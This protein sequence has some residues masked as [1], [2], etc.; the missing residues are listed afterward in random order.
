M[1]VVEPWR[2]NWDLERPL[3]GGGQGETYLVRSKADPNQRGVMKLQV[4]KRKNDAKS[5]QRMH[6]EVS[7][8]QIASSTTSKVPKVLDSNTHLHTRGDDLYFV[9]EY[10]EGE[11]LEDL[12]KREKAISPDEA[13]DLAIDLSKTLLACHKLSIMHRDLKPGNI[14]IRGRNPMNAVI[15]DYGLSFNEKEV[16]QNDLTSQGEPIGNGFT[17]LPERRTPDAQRHYE[18][19]LTAVMGILYYCVTGQRPNPF[20]DAHGDPPHKRKQPGLSIQEA[21]K[22]HA[23][24][25]RLGIVFDRAFEQIISDRFSSAQELIER[26]LHAKA[27]IAMEPKNLDEILKTRSSQIVSTSRKMQLHQYGEA[28]AKVIGTCANEL[29]KTRSDSKFP[30]A[31]LPTPNN[32]QYSIPFD[33]S[34]LGKGFAL[35]VSVIGVDEASIVEYTFAAQGT[36][37]AML[38]RRIVLQEMQKPQQTGNFMRFEQVDPQMVYMQQFIRKPVTL[39]PADW[40]VRLWFPGEG[41][42]DNNELMHEI[43]LCVEMLIDEIEERLR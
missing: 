23:A 39:T 29:G 22:G 30:L 27:A 1:T 14:I 31:C 21:M 33:M 16:E 15:V 5:R 38:R 36:Q 9:M 43:G 32:A 25:A 28:A 12:M 2:I 34:Y 7:N 11:S 13:L 6:Q 3:R 26:L 18:S 24:T 20:R 19:D 4:Q 40:E 8:L 42:P 10:I 37:T 17:D 41:Q 35:G